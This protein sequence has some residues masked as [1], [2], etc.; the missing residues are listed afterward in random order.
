MHRFVSSTIGGNYHILRESRCTKLERAISK[1][2]V[3][4]RREPW[5]SIIWKARRWSQSNE[6]SHGC[7]TM[8]RVIW[9]ALWHKVMGRKPGV[10]WKLNGLER[11]TVLR[12]TG[13]SIPS[14]IFK[15]FKAFRIVK[16]API[17][18]YTALEFMK[19]SWGPSAG[20]LGI[21]PPLLSISYYCPGHRVDFKTLTATPTTPNR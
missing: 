17:C 10:K 11:Q 16:I 7:E 2:S 15:P 5:R 21:M 18:I 6:R 19:N 20:I 8:G 13:A 3:T 12:S 1:R 9:A 4:V 14:R